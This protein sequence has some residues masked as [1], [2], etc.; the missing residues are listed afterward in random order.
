[1][2]QGLGLGLAIVRQLVELHGG[3][4]RAESAGKGKGATFT[5][6]LPVLAVRRDGDGT[7]D[8]SVPGTGLEGSRVLIVDD[9][10]DARDLL[11]LVI[12]QNGAE[13]KVAGS[14]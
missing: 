9:Q 5:I 3:M 6:D 14:A 4:V 12:A 10:A 8:A 11:A 13:V 2:H 7:G 1:R